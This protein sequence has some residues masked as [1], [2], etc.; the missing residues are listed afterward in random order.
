MSVDFSVGKSN[1]PEKFPVGRLRTGDEG[2]VG[3]FPY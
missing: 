1:F 2:W 3:Y